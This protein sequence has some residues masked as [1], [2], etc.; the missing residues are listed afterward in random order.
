MQEIE[1]RL[2]KK[3]LRVSIYGNCVNRTKCYSHVFPI[4][5]QAVKETPQCSSNSDKLF[6]LLTGNAD[7]R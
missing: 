4:S 3:K 1:S 5:T 7:K 2:S 6:P